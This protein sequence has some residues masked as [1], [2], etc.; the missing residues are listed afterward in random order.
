MDVSL[1]QS[2]INPAD[3]PLDRLAGDTRLTDQQKVGEA[4]RQFEA[5]LLRQI[6]T[7]AQKT[8]FKSKYTDDST[9]SSVY[10][11]MTVKQLADS[12]SR[13]GGLGLAKALNKQLAKQL[14]GQ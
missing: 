5:I 6:L 3:V 1:I 4:G 14:T 10:R 7:A 12:M 2:K 9:A 11:D 8:T 13:G